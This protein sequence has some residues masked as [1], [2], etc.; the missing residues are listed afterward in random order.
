MRL[1]IGNKTYSSWSLRPWMLMKHF[2]IPFE[3][4]LVKLD[5]PSTSADIKKYSAS[6]RVPALIDGDL[7]IWDSLAIMEYL[8]EKFPKYQMWPKD[9]RNRA[10]ARAISC[11]MHSGFS[12]LRQHLSFHA[13]KRF[14][15]YDTSAA[16]QDIARVQEIW[17]QAL[18]AGRGP[19][20]FGEFS[21]A[22]A[23]YAPVAGR[24]QTYGV[25]L[26]PGLQAYAERILSLPEVKE[27]YAGAER[28]DFQVAK[29]ERNP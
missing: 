27:W 20:L 19:F 16:A 14:K 5:L 10:Q 28:E 8:N 24:F 1:I 22:D 17:T 2:G 3:E 11:E 23:M 26:S 25:L 7:T 6:G 15:D 18:K 13:K 9:S 21:I 12:D 4:T 29:Y